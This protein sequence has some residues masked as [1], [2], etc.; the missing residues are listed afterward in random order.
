VKAGTA[1]T[2]V[3]SAVFTGKVK[4]RVKV[5]VLLPKPNTGSC[6]LPA[7]SNTTRS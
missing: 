5:R 4:S 3:S 2:A 7:L 6:Y 1:P